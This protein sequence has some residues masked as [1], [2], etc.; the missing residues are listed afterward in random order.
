MEMHGETVKFVTCV[1]R[2][3]GMISI[4]TAN[5][6]LTAKTFKNAIKHGA[7]SYNN[8]LFIRLD[9]CHFARRF[10][11]KSNVTL[12]YLQEHY[13][14]LVIKGIGIHTSFD[15]I[16]YAF[17]YRKKL[18]VSHITLHTP[19]ILNETIFTLIERGRAHCSKGL[20]YSESK[21]KVQLDQLA[22]RRKRVF[23]CGKNL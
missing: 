14:I 22:V 16:L 19:C 2:R 6:D 10:Q 12:N 9:I 7:F 8:L 20:V 17:F 4:L 11:W 15:I 1:T 23:R 5:A 18:S 3:Q 13:Q 21:M